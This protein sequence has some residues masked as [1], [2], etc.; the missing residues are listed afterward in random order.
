MEGNNTELTN[1]TT[2]RGTICPERKQEGAL[3]CFH[4]SAPIV[5]NPG[6]SASFVSVCC[7]CGPTW[8]HITTMVLGNVSDEDLVAAQMMHGHLVTL[9]KP[10]KRPQIVRR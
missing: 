2:P 5:Q 6:S 4:T 7:F 8:M 10:P 1:G 3:H 9:T